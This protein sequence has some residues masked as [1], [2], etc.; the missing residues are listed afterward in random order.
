[1]L[2]SRNRDL[3]PDG[4]GV[5]ALDDVRK[6][7]QAALEAERLLGEQLI[8]VWINETAG[9]E[10][11]DA[12]AWEQCMR[13]VAQADLVVVIYNGHAGW[14]RNPGGNGICQDEFLQT[15]QTSPAKLRLVALDF[16]SDFAR[17]LLG[18]SDFVAASS[19]NRR[20]ADLIDQAQLFR[21][22]ATDRTSL[23][24]EVRLA[25]I[26]GVTDLVAAGSREGRR[27]KN[28]LGPSLDWSRMSYRQR[29]EELEASLRGFL[30]DA[31]SAEAHDEGLL[32]R[33]GK[34][35]ILLVPHGVPAGFGQAEAR[36]LVGRPYLRDHERLV[37]DDDWLGPVHIIAC[38]KN[39]TESQVVSFLGHPDLYLV[40]APFGFFVADQLSFVQA[41][42]LTECTDLGAT[43]SACERLFDWLKVSGEEERLVIR[44][45]AR[46]KVLKSV[47]REQAVVKGVT[48]A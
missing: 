6:E 37:P 20:F 38:N 17:K 1:M 11:G 30:T 44:A 48:G 35:K 41:V 13:R 43:V 47:A 21:G 12:N 14:A 34:A 31:F 18:P 32:V 5:I 4:A 24:K 29:K 26:K 36:E 22:T 19:A 8:D 40:R 33:I 15:W 3:I 16:P 28:H 2:S 23:V 7:L 42:F 25:V 10:S 46:T 9:A 39:C 45:R 27:G